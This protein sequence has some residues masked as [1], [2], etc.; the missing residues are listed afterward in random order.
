MRV[1]PAQWST[2][3]SL[4]T[5]SPYP[6]LPAQVMP[7]SPSP[8]SC[9]TSIVQSFCLSN[10]VRPPRDSPFRSSLPSSPP[11]HAQ[12][13]AA[14]HHSSSSFFPPLRGPRLPRGAPRPRPKPP[15][16]PDP[17][18]S[19]IF[20]LLGRCCF[21]RASVEKS[22]SER[23]YSSWCDFGWTG[24]RAGGCRKEG[25]RRYRHFQW[26]RKRRF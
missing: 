1:K 12:P 6:P 8:C 3:S 4:F 21:C 23:E 15:R 9:F 16:A 10:S 18:A 19:A 11:N 22:S 13:F 20:G 5:I 14:T 7:H 25:W 26:C 2:S 24:S 17:A